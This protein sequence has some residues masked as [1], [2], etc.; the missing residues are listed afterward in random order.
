MRGN[1]HPKPTEFRAALKLISVAQFMMSSPRTNYESKDTPDLVNFVK[2]NIG[3]MPSEDEFELDLNCL[4]MLAEISSF[5]LDTCE[6]NGLYYLVGWAIHQVLKKSK[7][8]ACRNSLTDSQAAIDNA[9]SILTR[10]RSYTRDHNLTVDTTTYHLCHPARWIYVF[11]QKV[12]A[13]FRATVSGVHGDQKDPISIILAQIQLP[14]FPH[15]CHNP[16]EEILRKFITMRIRILAKERSREI[17]RQRQFA[18]K[19][20]ARSSSIK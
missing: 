14:L 10:I 16:I 20:A 8:L 7:C 6:S 11:F 19:S 1:S 4:E 17:A 2:N 9:D 12:E 5:S 18:G 15:Q 3:E 13:I